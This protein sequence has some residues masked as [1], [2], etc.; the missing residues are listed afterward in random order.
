MASRVPLL[1]DLL[2]EII[3]YGGVDLLW[4]F[5]LFLRMFVDITSKRNIIFR[6]LISLGPFPEFWHSANVISIS[7]GAPNPDKEHY[8]PISITPI[9][10]KVY[11]K[12]VSHEKYVFCQLLSLRIGKVWAAQM[13]C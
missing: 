13:H 10:S 12:L 7:K 3:T 2:L 4:V 6:G 1:K 9:L 11:P 8:C 5:P